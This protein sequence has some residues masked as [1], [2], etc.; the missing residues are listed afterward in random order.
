MSKFFKKPTISNFLGINSENLFENPYERH[1]RDYEYLK[2]VT[3]GRDDFPPKVRTI[4]KKVYDIPITK[5]VIVRHPLS[6]LMTGALN[7]VSL[8]EFK[9]RYEN[10]PYD[11]LYHLALFI[12]LSNGK[13]ILLEKNEVINA[14]EDPKIVQDDEVKEVSQ[15]PEGLTIR[16]MLDW[17]KEKLGDNFFKYNAG[18]NNCQSFVNSLIYKFSNTEEDRFVKQNT[19]ALFK[20]L[21]AFQKIVNSVT[22]LGAKINEI[23]EGAGLRK[24]HIQS[25]LF[26]KPYHLSKAKSWLK[27]HNYKFSDVDQKPEHIRFRQIEPSKKYKYITKAIDPHISFIIAY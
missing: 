6:D 18:T 14:V 20:N 11:K 2:T 10:E 13:S 24:P 15:F 9:K 16:M 8:G 26:K 19:E 12:Y 21:P 3:T 22:D 5:L 27:K 25:I 7:A 4:L 17:A 23:T 1:K